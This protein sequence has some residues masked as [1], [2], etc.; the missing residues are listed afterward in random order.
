M[1]RELH[2]A[3]LAIVP[4]VTVAFDHGLNV[5]TGET[6][7]GKSILV[8]AVSLLAGRRSSSED[9]RAGEEQAVVEG[10]LEFEPGAPVWNALQEA[11]VPREG[12]EVVLRRI[13]NSDGRSRAFVNNVSWT[14]SGLGQLAPHWIDMSG[15]HGQQLLLD[16]T[17]HTEVLDR[18]GGYE[19]LRATCAAH[20]EGVRKLDQE[21]AQ[22]QADREKAARERDFL[23]FQ[24]RELTEAKLQVNEDAELSAQHQRAAH[25]EKLARAAEAMETVMA[26]DEGAAAALARAMT[27]LKTASRM[28]ESLAPWMQEFEEISARIGDIGEKISAYR[29]KLDFDPGDVE[30]INERLA[31]LQSI[32]RKYG[33][34]EKA[35]AERD[36]AAQLLSALEDSSAREADLR[37]EREDVARKLLRVA[38]ELTTARSAAAK[39]FGQRVTKELQL[40][41]MPSAKLAVALA[42]LSADSGFVSVEGKWF[43]PQGAERARF[44]FAPNPGEGM[45]PL[46]SIVSGGELS[47][48]L[49]AIKGIS[50]GESDL[51]GITYLFDEVDSGIGGETAERVGIRLKSLAMPG[52][53]R[54][55]LCVTH[56]AQIACYADVHLR[57]GKE[58]RGG[59]TRATV[60]ALDSGSRKQELARMI[61]GIEITQRA[62]DHAGELLRK[63]GQPR[64]AL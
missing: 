16:E 57:V 60:A 20:F 23:S 24:V 28:D 62:L 50:M 51:C 15:Q 2:I 55:V 44:D 58:I 13:V 32:V 3:N 40:L 6:G 26:G 21:L 47:R 27:E 39:K 49:L 9:V 36:R 34:I 63:G 19:E 59:R 4:E 22:L 14:A 38:G 61:G 18:F 52:K 37:K 31:K 12:K 43:G 53:K 33:S 41:G 46:A 11:G 54:Q 7:A 8:D 10:I 5:L 17:E 25:A 29:K 48:V 30:R 1:L 45:R 35:V 64:A 42:P 56:L